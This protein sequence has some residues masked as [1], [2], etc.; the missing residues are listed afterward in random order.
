ME[1]RWNVGGDNDRLLAVQ[2]AAERRSHRVLHARCVRRERLVTR[3][4]HPYAIQ[5]ARNLFR[6][7]RLRDLRRHLLAFHRPHALHLHS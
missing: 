7:V 3:A 5:P 1:C 2:A 6:H 4:A